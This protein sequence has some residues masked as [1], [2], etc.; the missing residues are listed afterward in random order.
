MNKQQ[1]GID[2]EARSTFNVMFEEPV[3]LKGITGAREKEGAS[4]RQ[5]QLP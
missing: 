5:T 3:S 4:K 2:D 1:E